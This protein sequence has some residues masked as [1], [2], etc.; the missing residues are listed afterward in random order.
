[1][2]TVR[3]LTSPTPT[4]DWTSV[5]VCSDGSY[6]VEKDIMT[7]FPIKSDGKKWEIVQGVPVNEFSRGKI[8]ATVQ[9]LK[10][11]RDAVRELGLI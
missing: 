5:A 8:N 4:G 6:G 10:E 9:E 11:E 3:S 2:D 1:V 7:S